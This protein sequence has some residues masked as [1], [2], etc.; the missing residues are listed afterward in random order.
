MPIVTKAVTGLNDTDESKKGHTGGDENYLNGAIKVTLVQGVVP[1]DGTG[2]VCRLGD[3]HNGT[4]E[5][6]I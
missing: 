6:R 1:D 2:D 5:V 3:G 4:V